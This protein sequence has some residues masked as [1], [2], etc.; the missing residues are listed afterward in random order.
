MTGYLARMIFVRGSLSN[1]AGIHGTSTRLGCHA[2]GG[3]SAF[4]PGRRVLPVSPSVTPAGAGGTAY[5]GGATRSVSR[6]CASTT[7]R[8]AG[9]W[10]ATAPQA[11]A[12]ETNNPTRQFVMGRTPGT[13]NRR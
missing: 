7:V 6:R 12:I 5:G 11:A 2:E 10:D 13:P 8:K 4:M 1:V 3:A 9:I